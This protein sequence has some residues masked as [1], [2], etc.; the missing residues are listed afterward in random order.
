MIFANEKEIE[1][2]Q[3]DYPVGCRVVLDK[4]DDPYR[5]LPAGL[6]GTCRGVDDAGNVLVVWDNGSSLN[7]AYGTDRCHRVAKSTAIGR[8][9]IT[10]TLCEGCMTS[11][12][13][14]IKTTMANSGVY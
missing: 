3:R 8:S 2:L 10:M 5:K 1:H 9:G 12:Y 6:Q 14:E 4:M 11:L 13:S 7:V